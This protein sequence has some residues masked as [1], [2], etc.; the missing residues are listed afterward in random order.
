M[1]DDDDRVLE[2]S[3]TVSEVNWTP[4]SKES[5]ISSFISEEFPELL[6]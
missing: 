5:F 2:S 3:E 1:L 4:E 6:P